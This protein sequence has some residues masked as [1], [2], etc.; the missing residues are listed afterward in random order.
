MPCLRSFPPFPPVFLGA[1]GN[2]I[3][4]ADTLLCCRAGTAVALIC[5][6][7]GKQRFPY[8][9]SIV[10]RGRSVCSGQGRA[11]SRLDTAVWRRFGMKD[12]TFSVSVAR[13]K[14]MNDGYSQRCVGTR[15]FLSLGVW[16]SEREEGRIDGGHRRKSVVLVTL[17]LLSAA[18]PV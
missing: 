3:I 13:R 9:S 4:G 15:A 5:T 17:H 6:W 1:H 16:M 8:T 10:R 2:S 12:G 18:V 14:L 7:E 11:Q